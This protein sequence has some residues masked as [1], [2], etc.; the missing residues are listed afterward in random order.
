MARTRREANPPSMMLV[1]L[2]SWCELC[3]VAFA[4]AMHASLQVLSLARKTANSCNPLAGWAV[5]AAA[6]LADIFEWRLAG[7]KPGIGDRKV[8]QTSSHLYSFSIHRCCGP[9]AAFSTAALRHDSSSQYCCPNQVNSRG[10][11]RNNKG[12]SQSNSY[13]YSNARLLAG[14]FSK[15]IRRSLPST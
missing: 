9:Y 2:S 6:R 10:W 11:H 7:G 13:R 5:G 3:F 1:W 15:G 12:C 14:R 8:Y 4:I